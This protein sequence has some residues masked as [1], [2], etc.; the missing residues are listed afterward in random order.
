MQS[1]GERLEDARKRM[2]VSLREAAEA[3]KIRSDFLGYIEQDKMDF[4]LPDIYKRGFLK[5]Y[6][7]FLKLDADKIMADF[8]A[9]QLSH[10]R[11]GKKGGSEWFGQMDAKS[12][13]SENSQSSF[14]TDDQP[15]PYGR[16]APKPTKSTPASNDSD[17]RID[18]ADEEE[19][20]DKTFYL[21]V[22]LIFVGTLALVFVIFGLI[23]AILGS[24][25]SETIADEP[26]LR[27]PIAAESANE[28]NSSNG[29]NAAAD[30]NT[31]TLVASGNVYVLVKQQLDNQELLRRT[32][33]AGES[34]SLEKEGAVDILFTAGENL[35]IE[36][37]GERLRPSTP[38]TAK[39]TI[40]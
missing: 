3:T 27:A 40:E 39:I 7:R 14:D 15:A 24:D 19:A 18:P 5:N 17:E 9:Q 30:Q 38:G 28:T 12:S 22:G 29:N 25:D 1:I 26:E 21:K 36:H 23:W 31:L 35:V 4:D 2:G 8:N 10:T 6:A 37:G 32:L 20:D 33:S 11:L 13:E 34:V 16:I